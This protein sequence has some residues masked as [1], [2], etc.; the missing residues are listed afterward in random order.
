M[1][2]THRW[3]EKDDGEIVLVARDLLFVFSKETHVTSIPKVFHE[4]IHLH[5]LIDI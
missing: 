2:T 5:L 3:I 1:L 4:Q